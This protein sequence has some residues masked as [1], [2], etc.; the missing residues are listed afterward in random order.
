MPFSVSVSLGFRKPS[1]LRSYDGN[2][3]REVY[4]F[5]CEL[6]GTNPGES[7]DVA[8]GASSEVIVGKKRIIGRVIRELTIFAPFRVAFPRLLLET[9]LFFTRCQ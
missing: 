1:I 9:G 5:D 8:G 6:G 3:R 7:D 2:P 4:F